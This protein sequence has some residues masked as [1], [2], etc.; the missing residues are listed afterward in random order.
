MQRSEP[1]DVVRHPSEHAINKTCQS[2]LYHPYNIGRIKRFL[3]FE[4]RKSIV[5]AIVM[6]RIDYCNS[7]LYDVA[8]TNLSKLQQ[9][10]NAAVRLVCSLPRHEHVTSSFI[11]LHWLPIKFR[12]NFKIA[13]LCFKCLH[14]HARSYLK[15]TIA[16]KKTS[17]YNRR[18]ST[19][20]QLEDHSRDDRKKRLAIVEPFPMHPPRFGTVSRNHYSHSKILELSH[21]LKLT[22]SEKGLIYNFFL[23]FH[24]AYIFAF[25]CKFKI[26][27]TK[28]GLRHINIKYYCYYYY[29][30]YHYYYYYYYL[31]RK[32]FFLLK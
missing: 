1:R 26:V 9:V 3:S 6:S 30:Y 21:C 18:S 19:S 20:I 32:I 16:I 12:I 29:Y 4:D 25:Y 22:I 15:S 8:V 13:M 28:I 23:V 11:R 2:G 14:G 17:T 7:I 27:I 10:L 31:T 24:I 5:Q